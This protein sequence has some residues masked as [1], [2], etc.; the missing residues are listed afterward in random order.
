MSERAPRRMTLAEFLDR[1]RGQEVRYEPVDGFPRAIA[2][3]RVRHGIARSDADAC[4]RTALRAA[5]HG[6][7]PFGPDVGIQVAP[8][9]V[10]RPEPCMLCPPFDAEDTVGSTP[11]LVPEMLSDSTRQVDESVRADEHKG[12]A[13]PDYII[14]MPAREVDVADWSRGP[15]RARRRSHD[16][17]PADVVRLPLPGVSMPRAVLCEGIEARPAWRRAVG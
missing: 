2:G 4:P 13:S 1:Q 15:P 5:G 3:A 10:R 12:T 17:G 6:C 8:G 7:P 16:L 9:H 14:L 11:R